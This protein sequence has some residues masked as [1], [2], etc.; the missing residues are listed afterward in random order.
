MYC[1]NNIVFLLFVYPNL[2]WNSYLL[3]K[4]CL[5]IFVVN[6]Y[7]ILQLHLYLQTMTFTCW[8]RLLIRL[9]LI[10]LI[11]LFH[12]LLI[13]LFY[14]LKWVSTHYALVVGFITHSW[15]RCM[16]VLTGGKLDL[17]GSVPKPSFYLVSNH[18]SYADIC[19]LLASHRAT[20]FS[21]HD[22]NSWPIMG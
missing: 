11:T 20:F 5:S 21:K 9:P 7:H 12:I 3:A 17:Q 6:Y 18:L 10:C 2:K 15:G 22:L 4:E 14:P 16:M 8:I 19:V 1:L 13:V